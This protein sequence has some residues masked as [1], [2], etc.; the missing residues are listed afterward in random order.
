MAQQVKNP[1]S[2]REDADLIPG[3]AQWG[4]DL[5]VVTD[6][7]RI[8]CC[9]GLAWELP[10]AAGAAIKRKKKFHYLRNVYTVSLELIQHCRSMTG[11]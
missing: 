3:L 6:S 7:A 10:Y 11:Q 8:W 4:K 5:T 1:T 9:C 2:I